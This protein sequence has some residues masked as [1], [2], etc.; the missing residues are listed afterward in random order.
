MAPSCVIVGTKASSTVKNLGADEET[1][2]SFG[3]AVANLGVK[4]KIMA[5]TTIIKNE[6]LRWFLRLEN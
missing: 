5:P 4:A 1:R 6:A 2:E 3:V